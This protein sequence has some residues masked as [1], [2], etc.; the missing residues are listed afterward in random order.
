MGRFKHY[1]KF[2][3]FIERY[4]S[5]VDLFFYKLKRFFVSIYESKQALWDASDNFDWTYLA[6]ITQDKIKK[7]RKY[8]AECIY[9]NHCSDI[10][11]MDEIIDILDEIIADD[12][13]IRYYEENKTYDGCFD[14][15]KGL[16][17]K[18][19]KRLGELLSKKWSC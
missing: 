12:D 11:E 5:K 15:E 8:F 14:Y 3:R 18:R 7:M 2:R 13:F 16:N 17:D 9:H 1:K 10:K 6:I 19:F 4:I